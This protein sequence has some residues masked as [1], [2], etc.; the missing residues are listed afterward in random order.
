MN[1]TSNARLKKVHP[2]LADRV[3][4]LAEAL[5]KRGINIEVVQGV[6]TFA[7][8]DKLY[9]QGRSTKGQRVTNAK[10]GQSNHNYG[11]AVD[12]APTENG[13]IDWD[14]NRAF[15][16]IGEEAKKLG[17]KWG[18]DW[19][20]FVDKPHVELPSP[21]IAVM[22]KLFDKGGV[23]AVWKKIPSA[24]LA[25]EEKADPF[26]LNGAIEGGDPVATASGSDLAPAPT[27]AAVNT[28]APPKPENFAP[29]NVVM[30]PTVSDDQTSEKSAKVVKVGIGGIV[31]AW[32]GDNFGQAFGFF[33]DNA[34]L[35]KWVLIIAGT[36]LALYLLRQISK[37]LVDKVGTIIYNAISMWSHANGATNNVTMASPA[38]REEPK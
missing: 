7:E 1:S 15:L 38:P 27:E 24:D 29:Q 35:F 30:Q 3:R 28:P 25:D 16:T 36:L 33:K 32:L 31:L 9:A 22:R 10:G 19:K 17:L 2:L 34:G 14:D 8:Q 6:R 20:K 11:V 21:S 4:L 12:L 26:E 13:R 18:G 5:A 37:M 23:E